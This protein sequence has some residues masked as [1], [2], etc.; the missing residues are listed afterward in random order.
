MTVIEQIVF[1]IWVVAFVGVG[2]Y[3]ICSGYFI[4][5]A[6]GRPHLTRSEWRSLIPVRL[7]RFGY[8]SMGVFV[9]CMALLAVIS[10]VRRAF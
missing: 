1:T 2:I 9:G 10:L 4:M 3:T 6:I 5:G 7:R 8:W